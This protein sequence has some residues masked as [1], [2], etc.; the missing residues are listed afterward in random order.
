MKTCPFCA[1]NILDAAIVCKHCGRDLIKVLIP[2][3]SVAPPKTVPGPRWGRILLVVGF[4]LVVFV[5]M[6]MKSSPVTSN[7][8]QPASMFE[9]DP[10]D[11]GAYQ[12]AIV[13]AGEPCE[14]V[15]RTFNAGTDNRTGTT[16]V[17]VGCSGGHD[18]QVSGTGEAGSTRVLTCS[19][20]YMITKLRCF[21]RLQ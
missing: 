20:L 9:G 13:S 4:L 14:R 7:R 6:L 2:A 1:E 5:W 16:F 15:N 17:S 8:R 10:S 18:Y 3:T 19:M 21:E 12:R 11:Y